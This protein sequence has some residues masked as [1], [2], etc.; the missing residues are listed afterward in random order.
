M[1]DREGSPPGSSWSP[2]VLQILLDLDGSTE[3]KSRKVGFTF[4]AYWKA[5]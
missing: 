1:E 5:E 2:L 3:T 4:V